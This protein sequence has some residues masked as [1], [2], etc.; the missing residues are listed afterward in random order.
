MQ[1]TYKGTTCGGEKFWEKV[2]YFVGFIISMM[3]IFIKSE[4]F[5]VKTENCT[6]LQH[7]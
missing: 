7:I 3:N 5:F 4:E 1:E 2:V 6:P